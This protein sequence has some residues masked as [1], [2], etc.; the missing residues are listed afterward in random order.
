MKARQKQLQYKKS[1]K[2]YKKNSEI[3]FKMSVSDNVNQEHKDP[4][5]KTSTSDPGGSAKMD[6]FSLSNV[7]TFQDFKESAHQNLNSIQ[8]SQSL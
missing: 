8:E 1:L 7:S 5:Q 4:A 6:W 3:V 2:V